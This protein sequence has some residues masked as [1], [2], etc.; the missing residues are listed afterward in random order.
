[1]GNEREYTF[2]NCEKALLLEN[3][4]LT[5]SMEHLGLKRNHPCQIVFQH[6]LIK[7]VKYF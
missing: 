7:S 2:N 4:Y 1:M 6:I 5:P 3:Q